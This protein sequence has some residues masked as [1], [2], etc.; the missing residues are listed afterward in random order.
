MRSSHGCGKHAPPTCRSQ[1]A[2]SADGGSDGA[3]LRD[4]HQLEHVA[5]RVPEVDAEAAAPVVELAV[6]QAPGRA[7]V[8]D[9]ALLDAAEDGVEFALADVEGVVVALEL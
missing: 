9:L 3:L 5:V 2:R 4:G 6:S 8:D 1:R 7:A